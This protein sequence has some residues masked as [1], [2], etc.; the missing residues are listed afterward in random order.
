MMFNSRASK[1]EKEVEKLRGEVAELR[2]ILKIPILKEEE[3]CIDGTIYRKNHNG[4]YGMAGYAKV[5][6]TV[7]VVRELINTAGLVL[8][9]VPTPS[10]T[11]KLSPRTKPSKEN[12]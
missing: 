3:L 6:N 1:I 2:N 4:S 11:F 10:Q 8:E 5:V 9:E 7:D 12:V